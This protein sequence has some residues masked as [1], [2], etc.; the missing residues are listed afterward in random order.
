[1]ATLALASA[2]CASAAAAQPAD[3]GPARDALPG[4][5]RIGWAAPATRLGGAAL[6]RG[7]YA[8]LEGAEGEGG[9]HHRAE[10]TLA[11][12][13]QPHANVAFAL[14]ADGRVDVH[15]H[16]ALGGDTSALAYPWVLVRAGADVGSGFALGGDL[17]WEVHGGAAPSFDPLAS[18]LTLRALATWR[19][20]PALTL[21]LAGGARLDG[22][23]RSLDAIPHRTGD[24][25]SLDVTD[26]NALVLGVAGAWAHR[27]LE[28]FGELTWEPVAGTGAAPIERAPL[29]LTTGGRVAFAS[30]WSA[31]LAVEIGLAARG[32]VLLDQLVEV[33]PRAALLVSIAYRLDL[34]PA[35]AEE[36]AITGRVRAPDGSPVPDATIA[37]L[38]ETGPI[39]TARASESGQFTLA[40]GRGDEPRRLE[41]SA[42]FYERAVHVLDGDAPIVLELIPVPVILRGVVRDFEGQPVLAQV[43]IDEVDVVAT[44]ADG[45]FEAPIALG[46]HAI[47]VRAE[48]FAPQRRTLSV[49]ERGV[50]IVHV[51]LQRTR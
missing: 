28:L 10:G 40:L 23:R 29:R 44:R 11:V 18:R 49:E 45:S 20:T 46:T 25:V 3:R 5:A 1:M 7:G 14:G 26:G 41:V 48:G 32:P 19:P 31:E 37:V 38:G 17:R 34:G 2:L 27:E 39:A 33:E 21:G 6:A 24:R 4:A 8:I 51:D 35:A 13:A 43:H 50:F 42:P 30:G 47:E 16:D 36:R 15:P 22:T 12:S 9:D